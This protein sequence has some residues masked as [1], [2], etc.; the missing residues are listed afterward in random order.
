MVNKLYEAAPAIAA[1]IQK[2]LG[3]N[4]AMKQHQ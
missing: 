3:Y 1:S 2:L 4:G